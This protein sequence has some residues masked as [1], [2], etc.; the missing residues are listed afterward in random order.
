MFRA[1]SVHHQEFNDVNCTYL[2]TSPLAFMAGYAV[3][4]AF[5][6]RLDSGLNNSVSNY[7]YLT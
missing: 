2:H 7:K 1:Q 3:K 5:N 4:F 6:F